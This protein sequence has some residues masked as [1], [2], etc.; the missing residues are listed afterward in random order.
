M[1]KQKA[2]S[3]SVCRCNGSLGIAGADIPGCKKCDY[4]IVVKRNPLN[5]VSYSKKEKQNLN[6]K[7]LMLIL[8]M[9]MLGTLI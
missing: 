3:V 9:L 4:G 8:L 5:V 7:V 6:V 1:Q 2:F